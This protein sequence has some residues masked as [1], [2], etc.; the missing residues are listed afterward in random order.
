MSSHADSQLASHASSS[1][2]PESFAQRCEAAACRSCGW[3]GLRGVLDLG[4]MPPSDRMVSEAMAAE[5]D[6]RFPLELAFCPGCSLVQILET[7]PPEM[8]FGEHYVYYSSFS[9]ALLEHA[10]RNAEQLMSGVGL[11]EHSLV[12]ELA[13]ND[14]YLLRHFV[15]AGVPTLGIDPAPAQARAAAEAG[16]PTRC[17]FFTADLAEQLVAEGRRADVVIANNVLAH[18]ADTN[19]FVRGIAMI[20]KEEGLAVIEVPYVRELIENCEFDTIYHEHLCY[21][22]MTALDALF[23]RHGLWIH[24]VEP[25]VIHGGSLRLYVRRAEIERPKVEA[26]LEQERELGMTTTAFYDAFGQR[27]ERLRGQLRH[28]LDELRQRGRRVAAYGAA[29]KGTIMLNYLGLDRS[30]IEFV[31]DRNIHKHGR[32]MPGV[33]IPIHPVSMLD[34]RR[35]AYTLLLAWNFR[36]EI[37]A[38]QEAYRQRGGKFIVP[39][40]KMTIV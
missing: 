3:R 22:S 20:L 23:R 12:V 13:S 2:Q 36:D 32:Y 35:P 10:R 38:Q 34:E 14:G 11:D 7:V 24:D 40:P 25:L 8:L 17:A 18:V 33:R 5:A 9:E 39:L 21:F 37:L 29:A 4:A 15:A 6:P 30:W 19:G 31:V 28:L 1:T 16:V 26:M 27:V